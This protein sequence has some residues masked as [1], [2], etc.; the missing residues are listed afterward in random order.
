MAAK[1]DTTG[2]HDVSVMQACYGGHYSPY[3]L[4]RQAVF[5]AGGLLHGQVIRKTLV[6]TMPILCVLIASL[7]S[8]SAQ[9]G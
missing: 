7:N 5:M 2:W 3:Y 4:L 8:Y 6:D 9:F 1:V